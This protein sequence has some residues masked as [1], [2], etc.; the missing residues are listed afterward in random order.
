MHFPGTPYSQEILANTL[1]DFVNKTEREVVGGRKGGEKGGGGGGVSG[2]ASIWTK[3]IHKLFNNC[4]IK[5][6]NMLLDPMGVH[7]PYHAEQVMPSLIDQNTKIVRDVISFTRFLFF[8]FYFYIY[9]YLFFVSFCLFV[10][11]IPPLFLF[12]V[13][14]YQPPSNSAMLLLWKLIIS[15]FGFRLL[16]ILE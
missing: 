7:A 13:D 10:F 11:S 6:R 14:T 3:E 2:E 16:H 1:V 4:K 5:S 9:I 15:L 8:Y 12:D